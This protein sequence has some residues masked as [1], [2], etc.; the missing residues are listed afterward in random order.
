MV[1]VLVCSKDSQL[2]PGLSAALHPEFE[3]RVETDA[4]RIRE[5]TLSEQTEVL[6]L[7]FDSD[8]SDKTKLLE[9][10]DEIKSC[11]VPIV[12]MSDDANRSAALDLV[13]RSAFDYFRKPPALAELRTILRRANEHACLKREIR[14]VRETS[15]AKPACDQLVGQGPASLAVYDLIRRVSNLDA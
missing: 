15:Q 5:L 11:T 3:V 7:D 4:G 2:L 10:F 1:R 13:R 12:V 8:Y 6:I 14:K 9:M